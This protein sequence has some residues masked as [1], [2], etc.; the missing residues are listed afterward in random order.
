VLELRK[1]KLASIPETEGEM[2]NSIDR[3]ERE[4]EKN[5]I[6]VEDTRLPE[7]IEE[8][9]NQRHQRSNGRINQTTVLTS[10]LIESSKGNDERGND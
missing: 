2:V 8:E 4:E 1:G 3:I 5:E 9:Q 10:T 6:V 7:E